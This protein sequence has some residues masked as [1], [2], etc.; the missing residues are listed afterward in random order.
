[1]A[2]GLVYKA[3]TATPAATASPTKLVAAEL[4]PLAWIGGLP[5]P[6]AL[7]PDDGMPAL[8]DVLSDDGTDMPPVG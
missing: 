8:A 3:N 6:V 1:M 5:D 2:C 4:A 7:A